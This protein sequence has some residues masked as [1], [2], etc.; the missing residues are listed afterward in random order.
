MVVWYVVCG[1][2]VVMWWWH[3]PSLISAMSVTS[4]PSSVKRQS[5][6]RFIWCHPSSRV[7]EMSTLFSVLCTCRITKLLNG[8]VSIVEPY[9]PFSQRRMVRVVLDMTGRGAGRARDPC[10]ATLGRGVSVFLVGVRLPVSSATRRNRPCP[11]WQVKYG[12]PLTEP[13]F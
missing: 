9:C 8:I 10:V 13:S 5:T 6:L 11:A 1:G 2:G 3:T 7:A 12:M 4:V